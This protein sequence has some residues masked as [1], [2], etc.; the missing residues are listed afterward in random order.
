MWP[1]FSLYD[2]INN[3]KCLDGPVSKLKGGEFEGIRQM[4][5]GEGDKCLQ[6]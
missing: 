3:F 6:Y 1:A 2:C 5:S 4:K